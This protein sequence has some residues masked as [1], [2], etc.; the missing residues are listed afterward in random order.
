MRR[1]LLVAL[2]LAVSAKR[3]ARDASDAKPSAGRQIYMPTGP[4]R[5][6]GLSV[7]RPLLIVFFHVTALL[8]SDPSSAPP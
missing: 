3:R 8:T 5:F 7:S 4:A 6:S 2:L 1:P